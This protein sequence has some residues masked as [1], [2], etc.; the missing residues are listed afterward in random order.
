MLYQDGT[1]QDNMFP[2][3]RHGHLDADLLEKMGM[4]AEKMTN[5]DGLPDALF[6]RQLLYPMCNPSRSGIL[7]DPVRRTTPTL[8]VSPI[9]TLTTV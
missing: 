3:E 4:S 6:F 1:S 5:A 7:G 9:C 8:S 2:E